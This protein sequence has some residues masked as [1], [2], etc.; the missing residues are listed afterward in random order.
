M[1]LR[2]YLSWLH[3]I[4]QYAICKRSKVTELLPH[5]AKNMICCIDFYR[6]F[7]IS[8]FLRVVLLRW[9]PIMQIRFNNW[10]GWQKN[11]KCLRLPE[12]LIVLNPP[13]IVGIQSSRCQLE[14]IS[15][16]FMSYFNAL[17]QNV[18]KIHCAARRISFVA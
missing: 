2:K 11:C 14:N 16:Y 17:S 5:S 7:E 15:A 13:N 1:S 4:F 6:S 9:V 3:V 12:L 8:V 10:G 18:Q